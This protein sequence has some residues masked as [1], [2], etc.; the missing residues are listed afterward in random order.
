MLCG[1]G[2]EGWTGQASAWPL[3]SLWNRRRKLCDEHLEH[4]AKNVTLSQGDMGGATQDGGCL[5]KGKGQEQ[6]MASAPQVQ[7]YLMRR[8]VE[9]GKV[10]GWSGLG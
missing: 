4:N 7:A 10:G 8:I 1:L 3:L 6:T 9:V 2:H 5:T